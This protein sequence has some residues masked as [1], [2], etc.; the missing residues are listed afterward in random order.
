M[1]T[2]TPDSIGSDKLQELIESAPETNTD[3][4]G[5]YDGLTKDQ[6]GELV[7]RTLDTFDERCQ[8]PMAQKLMALIIISNGIGWHTMAGNKEFKNDDPKSATCWLRD[9]GKLQAAASLLEDV[10][11]GNDDFTFGK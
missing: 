9:A 8:H 11:Y 6:L 1:T 4:A 5:P 2:T 3:N 7:K 10:S